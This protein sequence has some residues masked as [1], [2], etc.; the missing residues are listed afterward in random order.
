MNQTSSLILPLDWTITNAI[1]KSFL[2][3][4]SKKMKEPIIPCIIIFFC[5]ISCQCLCFRQRYSRLQ[6]IIR[7]SVAIF[8]SCV[9]L[10]VGLA[11]VTKAITPT[12]SHP[13]HTTEAGVYAGDAGNVTTA[14]NMSLVVTLANTSHAR[15]EQDNITTFSP[16]IAG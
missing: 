13:S 7:I 6:I 1:Y 16:T 12:S 11:A 15:D 8:I 9:A 10:F 5:H 2:L 4:L 14:P 3:S